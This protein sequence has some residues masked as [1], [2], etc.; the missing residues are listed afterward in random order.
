M[1]NNKIIELLKSGNFT[2]AYHD[3]QSPALYKG[4]WEYEQLENKKE[5]PIDNFDDGYCPEIVAL[6]TKALGGKS[7]SV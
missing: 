1:T 6:L 2:I 3:N 4:H 5:I 7:T